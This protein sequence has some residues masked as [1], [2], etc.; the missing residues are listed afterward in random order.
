L[1]LVKDGP[2]FRAAGLNP[3]SA[4][5]RKEEPSGVAPAALLFFHIRQKD[6]EIVLSGN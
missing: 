3:A 6:R 5:I 1:V 2:F 4:D